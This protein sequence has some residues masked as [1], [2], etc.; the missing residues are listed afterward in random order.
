L[1][2]FYLGKI[3]ATT[4]YVSPACDFCSKLRVLNLQKIEKNVEKWASSTEILKKTESF[5]KF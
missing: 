2:E 5:N 3:A 4:T 1:I